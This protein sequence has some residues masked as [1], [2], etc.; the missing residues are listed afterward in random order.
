[1]HLQNVKDVN[2]KEWKSMFD[3]LSQAPGISQVHCSKRVFDLGKWNISTNH[4]FWETVKEW[5][6]KQLL[7]LYN[8]IPQDI[9]DN[10]N[11][12]ADFLGPHRLQHR[13]SLNT[14]KAQPSDYA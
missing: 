8:S 14:S 6:D 4:D 1:M 13:P 2:G 10:Y 9:R 3:A 12:Y 5:Q 11:Q 7:P